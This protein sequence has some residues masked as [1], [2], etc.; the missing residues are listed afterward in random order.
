MTVA[1]TSASEVQTAMYALLMPGGSLDTT[2][3]SL[4]LNAVYDIA[5]VPQNAAFDYLTIG[6]G[7]EMPNDTLGLAG[8]SDGFYYFHTMTIYSQQRNTANIDAMISRLHQIFHRVDLTLATLQ[9]VYT[10]AQRV[11]R[12]IDPSGTI[13]I[14]KASIT[15]KIYSVQP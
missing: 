9:H 11:T 15:Y 7:Y 13:P 6:Q 12:S 2:L 3:A 1:Y 4:G 8:H 10:L 5:N 14:L